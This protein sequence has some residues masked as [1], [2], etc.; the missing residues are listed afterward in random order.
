MGRGPEQTGL[1]VGIAHAGGEEPFGVEERGVGREGGAESRGQEVTS[2][3]AAAAGEMAREGP[4]QIG[5]QVVGREVWGGVAAGPTFGQTPEVTWAFAQNRLDDAAE[6]LQGAEP[7]QFVA[8]GA[9]GREQG[10]TRAVYLPHFKHHAGECGVDGEAGHGA[11]QIGDA[12]LGIDG[13]ERAEV[14]PGVGPGGGWGRRCPREVGGAPFRAEQGCLREVGVE[15]FGLRG[16]GQGALLACVP[17]TITDARAQ[18]SR[19]AAALVGAVHGNPHGHQTGEAVARQKTR[20][21]CQARIH[22]HAY[23]FDGERTLRDGGGQHDFPCAGGGRGHGEVLFAAVQRGVKRGHAHVRR[24]V[25]RTQRLGGI[26][27]FAL[28]RQKDEHRAGFLA[29]GLQ[30][31]R[32]RVETRQVARLHGIGNGGQIDAACLGERRLAERRGHDQKSQVG[33][34]GLTHFPGQRKGDIQRQG[35]FVKLIE[36]N[37]AR[38]GKLRVCQDTPRQKAFGKELNARARPHTPFQTHL[39]THCL[40]GAFAQALR[41][42]GRRPPRGQPPRLQHNNLLS[43]QPRFVQECRGHPSRL[44]RARRRGE[45]HRLIRSQGRLQFRQIQSHGPKDTI[46]SVLFRRRVPSLP[47]PGTHSTMQGVF[48]DPIRVSPRTR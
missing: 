47:S 2:R 11:A 12:P 25:C 29:Q 20:Y 34:Q 26:A 7:G 13:T 8:F 18:T 43:V 9:D 41:D 10:T 22:H 33:P 24:Q 19:A 44:A 28:A 5:G 30:G 17:E 46:K 21:A 3:T 35:S 23:A 40:A 15:D 6:V 38:V 48:P 42:K 45:R 4:E 39:P 1:G 36:D 14:V 37:Q 31:R 32:H 16:L 27:D